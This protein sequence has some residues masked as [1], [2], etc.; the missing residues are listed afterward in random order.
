MPKN[1]DGFI[2][3]VLQRL[4]TLLFVFRGMLLTL[5]FLIF[6]AFSTPLQES[7]E[8]AYIDPPRVRSCRFPVKV[9]Y[10]TVVGKPIF[11]C[12]GKMFLKRV[13]VTKETS[14]NSYNQ[15]FLDEFTTNH[16]VKSLLK[17][18]DPCC[19]QICLI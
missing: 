13:T 6:L 8:E 19:A 7:A 5:L 14:K 17:M 3:L 11:G 1:E 4:D 18:L 10:M 12:D 16:M 15:N 9:M 2:Y